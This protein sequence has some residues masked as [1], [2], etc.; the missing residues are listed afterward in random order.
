MASIE[1]LEARVETLAQTLD[2]RDG[3]IQALEA[4]AQAQST[5][6]DAL[7]GPPPDAAAG[8]RATSGAP[9]AS[10]AAAPRPIVMVSGCY[11]LLHSGHVAFFA[12]AARHGHLYVSV[13]NDANIN[14]LKGRPAMF[15]EAERCY[16]VRSI[17]HVRWASV[18]DGMG[19]LDWEADLDVIRPDVFFVNGDGDRPAKREACA[20]RGIRYVVAS[21][22][23]AAGLPVRSSTSIKAAL[24]QKTAAQAQPTAQK[25][26]V[27]VD[28]DEV[29]GGFLPALTLWHNR[30]YGTAFSL[31]DYR[32]YS[33]HELWGG[34]N[35]ATV[36][37]VHTFFD[38]D[39]FKSGVAPIP[40]AAETL[41]PLLPLCTF[42]V[43]TSRQHVIA[44]ATADWIEEHFAG[45]FDAIK[46]GNHYDL[47]SPD[48]D[49]PGDA[50]AGVVKRSKPDMC[51]DMGACAL[52]DDSAK[53]A[54]QCGGTMGE[55]FLTVLFGQYGWNTGPH[56]P[57][58]ADGTLPRLEAA[59]RVQRA[60]S[61]S[62]V[63]PLLRKHLESVMRQ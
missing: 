29:L 57:Q 18:C 37:K 6:I 15:P 45:I 38:S 11:D 61:W 34:T 54:A 46:M 39:E 28:L 20:R 44:Q 48:P 42:V 50:A 55:G 14:A 2:D 62:E 60:H 41:R 7:R 32:S 36:A 21:R 40:G 10:W 35:A 19:Y 25:P 1:E 8:A 63:G 16:M 26:V 13:G 33:Y 59:G 30:V 53:Y 4:L 12:D 24:K 51:R 43:A 52:I 3:Q 27:A 22:D 23:P 9:P 58:V 47:K 5:Q 56:V 49:A 31:S 17:R